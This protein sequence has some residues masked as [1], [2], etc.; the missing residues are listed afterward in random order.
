MSRRTV[1]LVAGAVLTAGIPLS[2]SDYLIDLTTEIAIYALFAMSLNVLVGYAGNVSFGH[3]AYFAIG[4]YTCAILLTTYEWPV[5]ASLPAA[6][7]FSAVCAGAI[8]FFCVRLTDIYFAMLTL[9]FAML[10]WSIAFKWRSVTGGDDGFLGVTLPQLL[11]SRTMF[12]FF[13][14][15]VVWAS[16]AALWMIC[17]SPFGRV[18]TAI[19]E[20]AMRA[21]FVGINTRMLRLAAFVVAGTFAGIAGGLFAMYNKGMYV[22]SAFWTESAQVLIMVLL[23]GM[24]SF[25]GPAIGAALLYLLDVL[26]NQYTEYWPAVLGTI[27]LLVV[28]IAPDGLVGLIRRNRPGGDGGKGGGS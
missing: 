9:A 21:A 5:Y 24:Y 7:L 16:I 12:Y 17:H 6:A 8:G 15:A 13:C 3:A 14:Q 4:G 1:A 25:F 18:L 2:G 22:E 19:R 28:L 27:L 26:A 23:G 10:V 11:T 20:N